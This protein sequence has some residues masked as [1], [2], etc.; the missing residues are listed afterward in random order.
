MLDIIA[1]NSRSFCDWYL[2]NVFPLWVNTYGRLTGLAPF[3]VGGIMLYA[4]V[5]LIF[6]FIVIGIMRLLFYKKKS[7]RLKK[8]FRCMLNVVTWV[9]VMAALVLT[10]NCYII[11]HCSS[12][13][14]MY[15]VGRT[16]TKYSS[17]EK[18][19]H[20]EIL[21]NY[22]VGQANSLS[23]EFERDDDGYIIY[24]G[25]MKS[26]AQKEMKRLG[27][28]YGQLSG[29]YPRPK[30]F[31]NSDFF[32]QQHMMGYY[33]P[34]S[35]EAN[36]NSTMYITNKPCTL[37]HELSH[38]KGFIYEDE[39]NFIGYLACIDSDDPLFQYSGYLSVLTYVDKDFYKSRGRDKAKYRTYPQI[40]RQ[41]K[42]D[43]V[44]LTSEEWS[45]VN[46]NAWISTKTVSTVSNTAVNV[47]LK[48]NG[49]KDGIVS[50]SRV[51]QRLMDYY[52]GVLW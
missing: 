37:C 39:A 50:Y 41:V 31:L 12:F 10:L 20:I 36:Y 34:F 44:F 3:S 7:G 18:S 49:V 14:E 17:D 43:D 35:M 52:D 38:L 26:Q 42:K 46:A 6:A 9:F 2:Q 28:S 21:R 13:M 16:H 1:W 45:R 25:D 23:D 33:Y 4:A 27:E 29:F 24:N 15:D 47:S 8:T 30:E 5:I 19:E 51:V 11:Y 48:T 40:S 22:I 32:S